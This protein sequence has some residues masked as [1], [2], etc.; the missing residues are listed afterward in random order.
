MHWLFNVKPHYEGSADICGWSEAE[1]CI[2]VYIRETLE[3]VCDILTLETERE[4][5]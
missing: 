1:T 3:D 2:H 5:V 4:I